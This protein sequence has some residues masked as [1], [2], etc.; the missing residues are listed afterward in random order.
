[1]GFSNR[2]QPFLD[3]PIHGNTHLGLY[4]SKNGHGEIW[5]IERLS[6]DFP[7]HDCRDG[8]SHQRRKKALSSKRKAFNSIKH[9]EL[10]DPWDFTDFTIKNGIWPALWLQTASE[11][12]LGLGV[13][14][15]NAFSEG[16]WST[17]AAK[18]NGDKFHC[19]WDLNNEPCWTNGMSPSNMVNNTNW[20]MEIYLYIARKT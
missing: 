8:G 20:N 5:H 18:K 19:S 7:Y 9:G 10:A 12:V 15:L 11:S 16:I 4:S 6:T 17:R 13:W 14:G 1:M 2:N 3:T